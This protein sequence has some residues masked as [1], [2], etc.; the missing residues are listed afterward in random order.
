MPSWPKCGNKAP[1]W[2]PDGFRILL[3]AS[4][5]GLMISSASAGTLTI[6]NTAAGTTPSRLGYNLGHFMPGSNAADW[7]RYSG[8]DAARIFISVA[9][10]EPADDLPPVGDGVS[11]ESGFFARRTLLRANAAS[12]AEPLDPAYVNWNYF[13]GKYAGTTSGNNKIKLDTTLTWFK[14]RGIAV[15][16]N[17]TA[18]PTRFPITGDTDW[19]GRWELWQHYYAHA[20]LLGRDHGVQQFSMFN[21]P[22]GWDG[23]T[24]TDWLRRKR[25]CSDAIQ[26]A[27]QDVNSRHGS[28]LAAKIFS[29]NT[30][31]G[32]E[33]YNTPGADEASTETWGHDVVSNRHLRLDNTVSAGWMNLHVY[34]YQ[35]YTTRTHAAGGLSGYVTDFDQ[36]R[37]LINA[38]MPGEPLLPMALTEFNVRTGASYDLTTATQDSPADFTALGANCIALTERG[39]DQLYLFKFAQTAS[40]STY[41]VAK[42]GTHYVQN[43][44]GGNYQYGGATQCAEVY[45]L[46]IK[47]SRGARP[48]LSILPGPGAGPTPNGGLW[49][50]ATRDPATG[51]YHLFLANKETTAQP[52]DLDFRALGLPAGQPWFVEEVSAAARGGIVQR[53]TLTDGRLD[54]SVIPAQAVRLFT[55][56]GGAEKPTIRTAAEDSNPS[57]GAEKNLTSSSA[58]LLTV[59][60]DG[61]VD[62]RRVAL[63]RIPVP[64]GPP[65]AHPAVLL[66]LNVATTSGTAP[67]QAHVYGITAPKWTE[68]AAT[69]ADSADILKQNVPAGNRIENNTIQSQGTS[70]TFLGQ[71]TADAPALKPHALDVTDFVH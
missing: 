7:F 20:Y 49:S 62:S 29:P 46:F 24:E 2:I 10:I 9:D 69:W 43:A 32:A 23:M 68:S 27:M 30:A 45:R 13:S 50:Q 34:N 16:A 14:Q 38:D 22:N 56:P 55:L 12:P 48:R 4:V 70:L 53:G 21:E 51:N 63:L 52:L 1:R 35:K 18:T 37:S 28:A 65:T 15:L 17:L 3:E 8:A 31:N 36:L 58:A 25:I 61:S 33:K 40:N 19:A 60:S 44:A 71:I 42:N 57:D 26:C 67:V 5:L 54:G 6:L 41:G 59:R 47:A 66:E 39:I 64:P 11:T